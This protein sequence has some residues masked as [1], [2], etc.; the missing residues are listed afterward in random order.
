[1]HSVTMTTHKIGIYM[2]NSSVELL[3]GGQVRFRGRSAIELL[4]SMT[5]RPRSTGSVIDRPF[6]L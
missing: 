5:R 3:N 6:G 4:I 2:K 1:M